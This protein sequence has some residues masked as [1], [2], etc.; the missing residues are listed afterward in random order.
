[1]KQIELLIH[2]KVFF[3]ETSL[4]FE[5]LIKIFLLS[6]ILRENSLKLEYHLSYWNQHWSS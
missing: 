2:E 6:E 1:M 4:Q 5:S 3:M